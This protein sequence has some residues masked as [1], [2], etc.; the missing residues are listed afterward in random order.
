MVPSIGIWH[1]EAQTSLTCHQVPESSSCTVGGGLRQGETMCDISML[2]RLPGDLR[3]ALLVF[4]KTRSTFQ[5]PPFQSQSSHTRPLESYGGLGLDGLTH[6]TRR[7]RTC[8]IQTPN[9]TFL[10]PMSF[11][12]E[13][14]G[15]L[16]GD[17]PCTLR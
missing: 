4:I 17:T 1:P 3:Y 8:D 11:M 2:R 16:Q 6:V 14:H 12:E 7:P 15:L 9:C 5:W 13:H 10:A